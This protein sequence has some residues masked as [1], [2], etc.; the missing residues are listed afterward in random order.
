MSETPDYVDE[1]AG[2]DSEAGIAVE[3]FSEGGEAQM[4]DTTGEGVPDFFIEQMADGTFVAM[5]DDDGNLTPDSVGVDF[6][7]DGTFEVMVTRQV[8][9]TYLVE[10]DQDGD[11]VHE[12]S[13]QMTYEELAQVEPGIVAML[14]SA[15]PGEAGAVTGDP[16]QVDPAGEVPAEEPVDEPTSP[17]VEDGQI[18]GDPTGDAEHWFEQAANG[19]CLPA[20]VAQIAS[21]YTGEHYDDEAYFVE[22]GNE[23]GIFVVGPDGVPGVG[24]DGAVALLEDAGIPASMEYG[25]GIDSLVGYL[26]EGRG[27]VLA[28]DSG[29]IWYGEETED[30]AADH[31]VVVTGVDVERG[32]V[33]VSDPGDPEGNAKEYPIEQFED[34]WEDSGYAAA[35]CDV[36]PE[37]LAGGE[38]P[39][40]PAEPVVPGVDDLGVPTGAESPAPVGL[41]T[42]G[43]GLDLTGAPGF[44]EPSAS[45]T[46]VGWAVQ[47]SWVLLPVALGA[48]LAYGAAKR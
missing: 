3:P 48:R 16:A 33:I 24:I 29:E 9:G 14:D 36:S 42:E 25:T 39:E 40:V 31:A 22:R 23:L 13:Q 26:E 38:A 2:P 46:A 32:V 41:P 17:Y 19:L 8:D 27:V 20:S 7:G 21:E 15:F 30:D 4:W 28:V 35:V 12:G 6:T 37:E 43:E 45:E 5:S 44:E 18:V 11:G 10:V 34:A 1:P 47:H